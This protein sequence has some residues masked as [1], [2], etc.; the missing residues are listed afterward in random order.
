MRRAPVALIPFPQKVAWQPGKLKV[1]Q[2]VIGTDVL[3]MIL[4]ALKYALTA[5]G[6][7]LASNQN[8]NA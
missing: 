6:I 2:M 5:N 7:T 1:K 4:H 3:P 8:K